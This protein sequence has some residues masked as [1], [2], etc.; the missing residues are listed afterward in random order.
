MRTTVGQRIAAGYAIIL[1]LLV[2]VAGIGVWT[3]ARTVDTYKHAL[4]ELERGLTAQLTIGQEAADARAIFLGYLIGLTD[5]SPQDWENKVA[6]V[7]RSL[8]AV[9]DAAGQPEVRAQWD[10]VLGLWAR[11]EE[12][13]RT[14]MA[15]VRE[16]RQL[17]AQAMTTQEIAPVRQQLFA[18][19][20]QLV[21]AERARVRAAAQAAADEVGRATLI[22]L[23]VGGLALALGSGAAWTLTRS[24]TVP[25]R[26]SIAA[27][28]SAADETLAATTQQVAGTAEQATAVQQ[29]ATTVNQVRQ[30]AQASA[31]RARAVAEQAQRAMQLLAERRSAIEDLVHGTQEARGQM[32]ALAAR[33]LTLSERA[34]A[35]GE[36][37]TT[38]NG[39]AE[40]SNLLA[41]N[42]AIEA[43]KAGEAGR[44][45]AVVAAEVKALAERSK[46]ATAQIREILNEVQRAT[47]AAVMAA[48][49]GVKASEA[50]E[51]R[52]LGTGE[53]L[54]QWTEAVIAMAQAAQQTAVAAQE[55]M[56]GTD[57]IAMAMQQI[58]QASAQNMASTRQVE[59][60][61]QDLH[62]I[63]ARLKALVEAADHAGS[64]GPRRG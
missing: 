62:E 60:S 33:I 55:Q 42:A 9:R 22:V 16:G 43:A 8:Q 56:A 4:D 38:V 59:R 46:E 28:A 39:L 12:G 13:A 53:T 11:W 54:R 37:V 20:D 63:A 25:L 5:A 41:V 52:A 3:A 19:I 34:Q 21:A 14:A 31:E 30:I 64:A 61:A 6:S 47:Q 44:G 51:R 49:Q 58:E 7:R 15:L 50:S 26:L 27:L 48:E 45:F 57:Q 23:A 2:L 17:Q 24:I 32:E 1:V 10:T 36:I 29:T 40:Q 35:I 18:L